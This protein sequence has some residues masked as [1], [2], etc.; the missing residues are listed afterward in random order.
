MAFVRGR[1]S[2]GAAVMRSALLLLLTAGVLLVRCAAASETPIEDEPEELP[3]DNCRN[4]DFEQLDFS[5]SAN[6][7]RVS[8]SLHENHDKIIRQIHILSSDIFD[9]TDPAEDRWLYRGFNRLHINTRENVIQAQLL[10]VEG[11]PLVVRR[12]EESERILRSRN[13]LTTAHIMPV[14]ICDGHID[15]LVVTR[16]AWVTEPEVYFGYEGGETR[17]GFGIK[18]GNFLGTGDNL[19]IGYTQD[20]FRRSISYDYRSPHLM[21]TRMVGRVYYA[22]KSDGSDTIFSL[23]RP[24]FSDD[25]LSACLF[26]TK[27]SPTHKAR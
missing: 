24:C 15:L 13:Y 17:S 25:T 12:V 14:V 9:E 18:D 3:G 11:E 21:G 27:P 4:T 10:F 20:E 16:D 26:I 7:R 22:E 1:V 5:Q 19:S 8:E 6:T 23:E 2:R